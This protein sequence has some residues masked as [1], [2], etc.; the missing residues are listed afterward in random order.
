MKTRTLLAA[1]V[2]LLI[3]L[4]AGT[5]VR[6]QAGSDV[7]EVVVTGQRISEYDVDSTP[8]VTVIRRADNLIIEV[9]V[10]CDTR[11]RGQRLDELKATIR[12]ILKEAAKDPR[13][14]LGQDTDEVIGGFD[15]TKLDEMISADVKADTS[16]AT[17]ILKT[18][19]TKDDTES[20]ATGRIEAFIKRVAKV[21]RT[22]ILEVGDYDLTLIGPAQY[23]GA[24][25]A[26]IAE[27]ARKAA[28]AFGP[29][30]QVKAI[31]LEHA[32]NWYRAG[33]LD[34]ALFIPYR[35]EISPLGR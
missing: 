17:F 16:Y 6:A 30:Y 11:E 13:I 12:N 1:G 24:V 31:G 15:E 9:K 29:D 28:A 14:A 25:I 22:E 4:G 23:R 10:V 3:A 8:A 5:M 19:V 26:A 35:L 20:S 34:L 33:P 18:N 7:A 2:A 32:L 21:G 27:D